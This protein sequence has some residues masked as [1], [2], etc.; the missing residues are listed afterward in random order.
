MKW[1]V[2]YLNLIQ[3]NDE[4]MREHSAVSEYW[5]TIEASEALD[6]Q[7]DKTIINKDMINTNFH[8]QHIESYNLVEKTLQRPAFYF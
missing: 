2:E 8:A 7:G 3:Y 1:N 5:S 4:C 6:K